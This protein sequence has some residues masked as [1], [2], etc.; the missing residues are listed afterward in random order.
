MPTLLD[1]LTLADVE[2]AVIL[3]LPIFTPPLALLELP[4][5]VI[6]P[7]L[8]VMARLLKIPSAIPLV[9]VLLPVNVIFPL[10]VDTLPSTLIPL[11]ALPLPADVPVNVI[12]PILEVMA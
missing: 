9:L 5:N 1:I 3:A 2:L 10:S 4:I 6:L 12:L 7:A 8:E 11:A